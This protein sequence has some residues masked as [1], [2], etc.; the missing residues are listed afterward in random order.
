MTE[1]L[2]QY[3]EMRAK[4]INDL[5][6]SKNPDPYPHK[7]QTTMNI[8]EFV[9]KYQHLARGESLQETEVA[10]AGRIMVKRD[11]GGLKFYNLHGDVTQ[12]SKFS[13]VGRQ[14]PDCCSDPILQIP[15]E[16]GSP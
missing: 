11:A 12:P 4:T 16:L 9:E 5:R 2:Q 6:T 7:F 10:L 8:P 1:E 14:N 15:G 3:F 13:D